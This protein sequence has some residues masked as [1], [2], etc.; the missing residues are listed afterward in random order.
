[1][2]YYYITI[3]GILCIQLV[4]GFIACRMR[5]HFVRNDEIKMFNQSITSPVLGWRHMSLVVYQVTINSN[6]YISARLETTWL[7]GQTTKQI[8]VPHVTGPL[9][10]EPQVSMDYI[11]RVSISW[12]LDRISTIISSGA[13]ISFALDNVI[14]ISYLR[15]ILY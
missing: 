5:S 8:T 6:I 3:D 11:E 10:R 2:K 1:M 4:I 13:V 14:M 7:K 12:C 9:W 15:C